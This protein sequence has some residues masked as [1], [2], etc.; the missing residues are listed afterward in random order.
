MRFAMLGFAVASVTWVATS[1]SHPGVNNV[2]I[3]AG[4]NRSSQSE[5]WNWSG[6]IAQGRGI[7][8]RAINGDVSA[9]VATGTEVEVSAVKRGRR[10]DPTDVRIEVVEHDGGI[11]I[12]AVYPGDNNR[13]AA[14]GGRMNTRNN[15]VDVSFTVRVPRGV[16]FDGNT[17]NGDVEA[18]GLTGDVD[19]NTVNGSVRLETQGGDASGSSV[20][21]GVTAIVHSIGQ[22]A[23]KFH[24]VNGSV[25]VTLPAGIDASVEARTVNGSIDTDFPITVNGRM[26]ARRISGT[27]GRGG[28][29]LD[30][31][32]VNG[33]IRLRKLP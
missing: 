33:S 29:Q 19:A 9:E 15:D 4:A 17:V 26:T 8:I 5:R 7:E 13:C 1:R 31:E 28:R 32:T 3:S 23:M 6:R 21:G 30:L 11:T 12:C 2:K 24:S 10:S 18:T 20:N 22:R 14:G 27:I 25:N 16:S